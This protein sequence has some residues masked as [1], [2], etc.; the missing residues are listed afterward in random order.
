M[1]PELERHVHQLA[2]EM[3]VVVIPSWAVEYVSEDC[4]E[5]CGAA[6][7]LWAE[8]GQDG[9]QMIWVSVD[10][11]TAEAYLVALHELGHHAVPEPGPCSDELER[12]ERAWLWAEQ[13]SLIPIT[14]HLRAFIE[15]RLETYRD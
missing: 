4:D 2:R 7:E 12:E 5:P 10:P 13:Q 11:V 15:R 9:L 14:P 3:G 1:S 8:F 6:G